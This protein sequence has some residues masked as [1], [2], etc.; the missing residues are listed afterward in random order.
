[1]RRDTTP[2]EYAEQFEVRLMEFIEIQF[3]TRAE[4]I[5]EEL[6]RLYL[7]IDQLQ[8]GDDPEY[9]FKGLYHIAQKFGLTRYINANK[10]KI[11][12]LKGLSSQPIENSKDSFENQ[13]FPDY[14]G[15]LKMTP[16]EAVE[17]I[18]A[19]HTAGCLKVSL[20]ETYDIFSTLIG[21]EINGKKISGNIKER[22]T[23][24]FLEKLIEGWD[25]FI[26]SKKAF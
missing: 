10:R 6:E 17:L 14:K 19:L 20:S 16:T 3:G 26:S 9:M 23:P 5:D 22:V 21:I 25:D 13:A 24:Y 18:R 1:M 8:G 15:C 7:E 11:E 12:F 4:F 2:K